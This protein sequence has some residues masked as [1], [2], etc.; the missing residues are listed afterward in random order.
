VCDG[1]ILESDVELLSALEQVGTDSVADSLTLCD[2]F[3]GIE[4]GD[5]R[6]EDFVSD[7]RE[8]TLIVVLAETLDYLHQFPNIASVGW[9]SVPG[10][11]GVAVEPRVCGGLSESS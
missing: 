5:D 4:L 7:G 9:G 1:D 2:Q 10:K 11:S 6:L 8:D 3:C